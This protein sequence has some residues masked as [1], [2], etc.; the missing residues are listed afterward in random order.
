MINKLD[1]WYVGGF[2]VWGSLFGV[3]GS[4]FGFVV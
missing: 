1:E 2:A 3:W 4:L